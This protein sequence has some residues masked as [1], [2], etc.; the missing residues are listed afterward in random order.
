VST[1]TFVA[2]ARDRT[3]WGIHA[4]IVHAIVGIR[5]W[6][7]REPVDVSRALGLTA[8]PA[9]PPPAVLLLGAR[10]HP[11]PIRALGTIVLRQI[12]L[13]AVWPV[14]QLVRSMSR[15]PAIA[16]VAFDAGDLP[17]LV[18]DPIA[19]LAMAEERATP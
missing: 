3:F 15:C 12:E 17:L 18:L 11:A 10:E 2:M 6:E 14:P 9:G 19:L 13:T 5:E 1:A 8:A 4:Q 7:G 16:A